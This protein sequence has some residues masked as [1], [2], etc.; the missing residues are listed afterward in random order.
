IQRAWV[1]PNRE[2][3]HDCSV[4]YVSFGDSVFLALTP[5]PTPLS[6]S[7][8]RL[9][10]GVGVRVRRGSSSIILVV[11][12]VFGLLLRR[13]L[14]ADRGSHEQFIA[15]CS[16]FERVIRRTNGASDFAETGYTLTVGL[17]I[18]FWL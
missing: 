5:T 13:P 10:L 16:L 8:S 18:S 11:R 6:M 1:L 4:Q 17:L 14:G 7:S 3:A 15:S 12:P 9:R 2:T